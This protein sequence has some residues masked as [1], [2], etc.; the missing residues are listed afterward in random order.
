MSLV[1]GDGGS[2]LVEQCMPRLCR[3]GIVSKHAWSLAYDH[4]TAVLQR[5]DDTCKLS[6]AHQT[7]MLCNCFCAGVLQAVVRLSHAMHAQACRPHCTTNESHPTSYV[8]VMP[9][10]ISVFS[11][12]QYAVEAG[13]LHTPRSAAGRSTRKFSLVTPRNF[14][15]QPARF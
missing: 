4:T 15:G 6:A 8:R 2:H 5:S 3:C 9:P 12:C 7:I 14:R 10:G 11:Q 1:G 13:C